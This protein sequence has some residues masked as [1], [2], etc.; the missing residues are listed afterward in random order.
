MAIL[1]TVQETVCP[2]GVAQKLAPRRD[3]SR[4]RH[5]RRSA[6]VPAVEVRCRRAGVEPNIRV[7]FAVLSRMTPGIVQDVRQELL[8]LERR[9]HATRMITLDE[10]RSATSGDAVDGL[11]QPYTEALHAR[12]R[13]RR[14]SVSITRCRWVRC[15][16]YCTRR[17]PNRSLPPA[18][19]RRTAEKVFRFRKLLTVFRT[20]SVTWTGNCRDCDGRRSWVTPPAGRVRGRPRTRPFTELERPRRSAMSNITRAE[21]FVAYFRHRF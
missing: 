7:A 10:Y 11:R 12:A 21:L 14:S 16:E 6:A 2:P 5:G 8:E 17:I 4:V 3:R 9:L 19:A 15:T 1:P 18:N 13:Q 20:R